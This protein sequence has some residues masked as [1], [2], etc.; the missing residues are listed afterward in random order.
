MNVDQKFSTSLSTT[1]TLAPVP[2][3]FR[4]AK[5]TEQFLGSPQTHREIV[6]GLLLDER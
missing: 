6:A 5:V 2:L 3:Y 4:R 1:V